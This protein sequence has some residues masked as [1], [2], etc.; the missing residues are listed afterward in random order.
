MSDSFATARLFCPWDFRGKNTEVDCNFLL[1]GIFPT[2][3]WNPCLLLFLHWQGDSLPLSHLETSNSTS[4]YFSRGNKNINL[5]RH[6][7]SY[8]GLPRWLSGKETA[9]RYKRY[10]R[11]GFDPWAGEIFW[12]RE[13][14]P[15]PVFLP[16]EF[17]G[18]RSLVGYNPWGCKESDIFEYACMHMHSYVR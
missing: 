6:M 18:Q 4:G 15:T 14:Q 16:G 8:A 10:K 7:N 13:W 5:R 17:H 9:C 1:Q 2:Q 3:G 11:H 12:R